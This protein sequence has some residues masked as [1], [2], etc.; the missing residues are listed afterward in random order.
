MKKLFSD[1][2]VDET[3]FPSV[4]KAKEKESRFEFEL[5]LY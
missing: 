4:M 5:S 2:E 1:E 3:D